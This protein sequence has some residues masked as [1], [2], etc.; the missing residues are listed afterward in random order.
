MASVKVAWRGRRADDVAR[1][2]APTRRELIWENLS[3]VR[4][5]VQTWRLSQ[6]HT[7]PMCHGRGPDFLVLRVQL[8]PRQQVTRLD[9][10]APAYH[11]VMWLKREEGMWWLWAL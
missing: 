10:D 7:D 1:H 5:R 2:F 8:Q 3:V 6:W 11:E 4:A 9:D